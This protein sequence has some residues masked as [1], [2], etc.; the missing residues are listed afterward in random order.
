MLQRDGQLELDA[1]GMTG[2]VEQLDELLVG[3]RSGHEPTFPH[4]LRARITHCG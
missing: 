4:S 3:C 2:E 1:V